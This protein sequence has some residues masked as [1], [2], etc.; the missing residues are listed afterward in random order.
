[1]GSNEQ[2]V[3]TVDDEIAYN[4]YK[5]TADKILQLLEKIRNDSSA[6]AKRWVWELL[7]NAKDVPNRFGKVSVEIELV[8][9]DTLKFRHNGD[10]FTTKN[11]TGLVQQV[12][13][14][15]SQNLEGQTGKF[16]TGF[17]C[18]HLISDIIDVDGVV[19]YMGANRRFSITLDRSG[20]RSEDLLPRIESTLEKL[21]HI[22]TAYP[23]VND[24]EAT[25]TEQSFDT[26]F[27]YHLTSEEKQKSAVAGLDDLIN[28]LPLTLVT[29]S[30]KIKQVRV[31]NRLKGTDVI[32]TCN[33]ES[34]NDNVHISNVVINDANKIFL[35]YITEDVALMT[36]VYEKNGTFEIVKRDS[37]Q[38]VLYRDFPL[39]GSEKFYFPYI[40]NG[41]EFN[42]TERRNGLY[43]NS[44]DRPSSVINRQIVEKA[45]EA[46]L[47]FNEWLII[48]N[49]TNRYLLASSRIPE[50][51]EIYSDDVAKPWI[52]NL[53][54]KWRKQLLDQELVETE[55]GAAV[56]RNLSV[57][58][59]SGSATKEINETFYLILH[60]QY[61]GRGVLP[62]YEQLH[63]WIDVIR[64]EYDSWGTKLKYEKDDFLTDLSGL[65]N[66]SALCV[67]INKT[68]S[69]SL[70]WLN[71]V[72]EFLIKRIEQNTLADFDKF[73][74]IPNQKGEFKLLKDLKSDHSYRIPEKLK[75]IYN[76]VNQENASIQHVLMNANV[77]A[78]VFGNTLQKFSLKE[79]IE[80]LNNYVKQGTN[81]VK[82][83]MVIDTKSVVA[84]SL[85]AL[86]PKMEDAIFSKKRHDIYEFCKAY[87][88]MPE[89]NIIDVEETDLWKETDNYWFNNSFTNIA[90]KSNVSTI[91]AS[92]FIPAKTEDETLAWLNTYLQF[93]RDNSF[94]DII[95]SQT[96]FP[97]QQN[98][99][100][101]L[102]DLRYDCSIPEAFK[103]LAN[104]AGNPTNP[105][106]FYRHQLL[107]KAIHGYEQQNP[108]TI[109]DI[110]EFVKKTFDNSNDSTKEVI[111]RQT[112]AIL[113]KQD[114]G[115]PE[116]KK[117]YDFAKTISG[118][119][120]NDAKHIE[121]HS[122]F[123]WGFAQDY[124]IKL[125]ACKIANTI[126]IDGF[127]RL[128]SSFEG[129]D[130]MELIR[131][132]DSFIEFLHGYKNKKYWSII[133][134]K[135]NGVGV[136]LNQNKNFCRFQDVRYDNNI[137]EELKDV[138]ANNKHINRDFREELFT[139]N[140]SLTSY[141][142]TMPMTLK[143]IGEFVDEKIKLYDG[144]KQDNEFRSLVFTIGKL[145]NKIDDLEDIMTYF[146][147]TR[148]S[149]IVWSLGEGTTMDLVGS[150]VQQG[151]EKL[152]MVKDI[153]EKNSIEELNRLNQIVNDSSF[154]KVKNIVDQLIN[155]DENTS[156]QILELAQCDKTQIS[157]IQKILKDY[158][159]LDFYHILMLLKQEQGDF[160]TYRFQQT[161]SDERKRE[162]GDKGECYVYE[163]LCDRFGRSNVR[164]S[165]YAPNDENARII[166]FNGRQ[167]HLK[168]TA[169]DFDFIVPHN[170]KTIYIE[171]KTTVG[172][173]KN[174]KDFPLIFEPKEWEWID[175]NNSDDALHYIV[176]VFDIEGSPKAYFLKQ[177]LN[178]D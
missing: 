154:D 131:W 171:V 151:D 145:F 95:K 128:S 83:D 2:I 169:H 142:E 59:F 44:A 66:L 43:F 152:K 63:E 81:I 1:M 21:R 122:G 103:D 139:L 138:C 58:V 70:E 55:N 101:K 87:R 170:G 130:D 112:I 48:H 168:T 37:K 36:E 118:Y 9:Q 30:S 33:S 42:P 19:T 12:S 60:G 165:N 29:Q 163:I 140:S 84:H 133:T 161:I 175:V 51:S 124:Y 129:Y 143:D 93:Y 89:Y 172:N 77:N 123:Y 65:Q 5:L 15:D 111:A 177:E 97:N 57:P 113:I 174:S 156:R 117:L 22:E 41:F 76:S 108:L 64:P 10:T 137:P 20:N 92:F 173:I 153:L 119:T 167:Y 18:T 96:V 8:S 71:K 150:I 4:N 28:T 56:L 176:R 100:K 88:T 75:E 134:D 116:E 25:R 49:V 54:L 147:E 149:L 99:L 53:Q 160:N 16:G 114:Y 85:I 69:E 82:N 68:E 17:I 121:S 46:V 107:H 148:N 136:W 94:G 115:E 3:R 164:W 98:E 144:N 26:V 120:F 73:A 146:K 158:P 125:L 126:N 80:A 23:V 104:Y 159:T 91:A 11:I 127:K 78:A 74:I 105:T 34:L 13:S 102:E 135:E 52:K 62:K 27:T 40:L 61:I 50:P 31:I 110:Y 32:Y 38:P 45:V 109:K 106:D 178:V 155:M 24:Y 14:K 79:M 6:S 86:C 162:I 7:Q 90:N 67:K 157:A 166:S 39:I 132:I 35:S 72:Y 141:L 47:K